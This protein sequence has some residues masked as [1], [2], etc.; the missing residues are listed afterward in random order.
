MIFEA[1]VGGQ[2][3]NLELGGD[4]DQ[5]I[6]KIDGMAPHL[7]LVQLSTYTYSLIVDGQ[8]HTLSISPHDKGYEV[9]LR[10]QT[11]RV[12]LRDELD[13]T[14]ERLGLEDTAEDQGGKVIAPIPGLVTVVKIEVGDKVHEGDALLVLEAMKMENDIISQVSG[15][16]IAIH[17]A[18][19]AAVEKGT[20]LLELGE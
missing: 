12:Q 14:I 20:L 18:P 17:V 5:P 16:V 3:F 15:K 2:T 9:T 1:K 19:G 8:S 7:D 11:Y 10:Q 13:M 4:A 6:V